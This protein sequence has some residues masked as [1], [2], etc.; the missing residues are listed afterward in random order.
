MTSHHM[1]DLEIFINGMHKTIFILTTFRQMI[2]NEVKVLL[3]SLF[4]INYISASICEIVHP[5]I[6][7]INWRLCAGQNQPE[8]ITELKLYK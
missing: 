5:H 7:H 2:T 6:H 8:S 3:V 4:I 1:I